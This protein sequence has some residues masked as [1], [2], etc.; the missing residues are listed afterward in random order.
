MR[1]LRKTVAGVIIILVVSAVIFSIFRY[2]DYKKY[3]ELLADEISELQSYYG[4]T[5][6]SQAPYVVLDEEGFDESDDAQ[7]KE[8][9]NFIAENYF[10]YVTEGDVLK[11]GYVVKKNDI[12][13]EIIYN[14]KNNKYTVEEYSEYVREVN[15]SVDTDNQA[16]RY[17]DFYLISSKGNK[18]HLFSVKSLYSD[19][20][21]IDDFIK[22]TKTS[23]DWDNIGAINLMQDVS[24]RKI[25]DDIVQFYR[26]VTY[27]NA[28]AGCGY[29]YIFQ[30]DGKTGICYICYS[31]NSFV[32]I[33]YIPSEDRY[34][35]KEYT[36]IYRNDEAGNVSY[37]LSNL[38]K[39]ADYEKNNIFDDSVRD[40]LY[41]LPVTK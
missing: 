11:L 41:V 36:G 1:I 15:G 3:S 32:H 8:I 29:R 5:D 10:R 27:D 12:Y 40:Y 14:P 33:A 17:L 28:W 18:R 39:D 2:A 23:G 7:A 21:G 4:I 9:H 30:E 35:F 6:S 31:H 13:Y 25:S 22:W 26:E 38:D 24:S 19:Y 16:V 37:I 34:D 20:T